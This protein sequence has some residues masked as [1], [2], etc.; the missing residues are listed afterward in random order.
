MA[1]GLY[2]KLWANRQ[3]GLSQ[4]LISGKTVLI[5]GG[6][7]GI[8]YETAK[9]LLQR[10]ARVIIACRNLSKGREASDNLVIETG[11]D[12]KNI[13]LMECDLCSLDSVRNFAKIYDENEER[14]DILICNAGLGWS[15]Q[16][17]TDD[18]FNTVIQANYLGHFLLTNLLLQK[19]KQ[20][21]PSRIINV[22][23]DLH[24][25]VKTIDWSDALIQNQSSRWTG[26]YPSSNLFKILMAFKLK[27]DLLA[28]GVD[29]FALTPGWVSS[30]IQDPT[31]E[32]LG[33]FGRIFYTPFIGL[34]K[35]AFAKTPADGAC[36][37]VYCAVEPSLEKTEDLY[38]ENCTV[39]KPSSLAVDQSSADQLYKISCESVGL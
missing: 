39:G 23:S 20:C 15:S 13:E 33:W 34:L 30:S 37:V 25:H 12:K 21:R 38:F 36:T 27:Q 31:A 35:Y 10:G 26:A 1:T 22:S 2:N 4:Q 19:L 24:K 8:G 16:T 28:E 14:L 32:A 17:L 29:I 5:T 7:S 9:E 3:P 11:C 6:N 18:G